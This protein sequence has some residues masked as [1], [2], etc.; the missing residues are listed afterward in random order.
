MVPQLAKGDYE[1][2]EKS[3]NVTLT[4]CP[5]P[6]SLDGAQRLFCQGERLA[7]LSCLHEF[8]GPLA[9]DIGPL[10]LLLLFR[11]Q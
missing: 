9:E 3:R 1:L 11:C 8:D 6:V 4:G 2:D 10:Q 7:R 5:S